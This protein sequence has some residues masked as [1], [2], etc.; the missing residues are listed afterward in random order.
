MKIT[1][2]KKLYFV[3]DGAKRG[4]MTMFR[5]RFHPTQPVLLAQCA[6]RRIASWNLD[7]EAEQ[8][9]GKK[10]KC[11]VGQLICPHE[12]GWVR[13]FAVS[14]NGRKVATGGSDRT[15][16]LWDWDSEKPG[17]QLTSKVTAHDGWVDAV[18]FSPSGEHLATAGAD[19]LIKIWDAT[20]L[21]PIETLAGH[22]KYACDVAFSPNGKLLVS[23]AED[24]L[25]IVRDAPTFEEIRRLEFSSTNEQFGQQPKHSGVHRL[26][27]SHDSRWLSIAGGEKLNVYDL[28][29]GELVATEK[30]QMDVA[31]HPSSDVLV[32]GESEA[33]V[34]MCD[35]GKFAPPEKDKNGKSKAPSGISGK[36]LTS[37]KRGS[38]SLGLRF[39]HDGKQ[40]AVGKSDGTVEMYDV[41]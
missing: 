31:F 26:A 21:K 28:A 33:K 41:V 1:K 2:S 36:L 37:I 4:P 8:I 35:T 25:A 16:R 6:D 39:S 15:L 38:W 34:W 30:V 9:K 18:A 32:G 5:V 24:G 23:G 3:D 29:N 7:G 13:G 11:V 27:I 12:I 10:E 40:L 17:E 20:D 14:P 22:Q 19:S